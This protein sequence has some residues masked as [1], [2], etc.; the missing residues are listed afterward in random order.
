MPKDLGRAHDECILM[1]ESKN[2]ETEANAIAKKFPKVEKILPKIQKF[3]YKGE[4]YSI[5]APKDIKDIVMEGHV[6][7]HCVH[8]CDYYFARI[9]TNESYL[10]FLRKNES[11]DMP[12]YTLEV[13]SS[14]NIRQKR[15]TGDNQ[16]EDLKDALPFLREWQAYFKKKMTAQEKKNGR[17]AD[18]LRKKNYEELRKNQNTI[19]HGKLAGQLLADVLE[20]DLMEA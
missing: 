10:F 19:W 1:L 15:T 6:L 13:E 11:P 14:G 16:N 5:I 7:R 4:Q 20:M 17:R 12:W 9:Q 8:T 18:A 2:A 3:E